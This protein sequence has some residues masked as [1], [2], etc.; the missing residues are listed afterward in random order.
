[1][2]FSFSFILALCACVL[3]SA[4]GGDH[5]TTA[6]KSLGGPCEYETI[7]GH[8]TISEVKNA[9]ADGYNCQDAVEVIFTFMPDDPLAAAGYRFADYSDTDRRFTL[10]AGMNPP[11]QWAQR[12]GLV[13][14][15]RHRCIRREIV[16][17]TCVPVT[18]FFP[19]IDIAGWEQACFKTGGK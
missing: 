17:G 14:G 9:P 8:A 6:G 3:L 19:D 2:P 13:P 18:Y 12:A 1:M 10:G 16:K 4:V 7:D 5:G 15:S 11:R